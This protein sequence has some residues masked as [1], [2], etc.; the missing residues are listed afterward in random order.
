MNIAMRLRDERKRLGQSQEQFG[1]IG[2]VQK[3]SQMNYE[4]GDRSPDAN[5]LAAI[6]AAGA[7]VRYILTGLRDGPVSLVLSTEEQAMVAHMRESTPQL[8]KAAIWALASGLSCDVAGSVQSMSGDVR[9][10]AVRGNVKTVSGD[11]THN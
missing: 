4:K 8:R 7:D 3:R 5:Y 10:G 2:G 9:C 6:E 1:L 11:I